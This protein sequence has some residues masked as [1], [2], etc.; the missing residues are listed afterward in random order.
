MAGHVQEM[1][2]HVKRYYKTEALLLEFLMDDP[3]DFEDLA[4]SEG[5]AV[6]HL[7]NLGL[8]N[9]DGHAYA[10]NSLLELAR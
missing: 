3:A 8:V 5:Q 4:R 9:E 2:N 10:L 7:V 1:L 6:R